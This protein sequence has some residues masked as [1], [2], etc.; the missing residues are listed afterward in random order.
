MVCY[1]I[2]WS[3]QFE[4]DRMGFRLSSRREFIFFTRTKI[5]AHLKAI[6][7]TRHGRVRAFD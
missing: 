3:G 1:G 4:D 5:P 6:S 2:F 7:G